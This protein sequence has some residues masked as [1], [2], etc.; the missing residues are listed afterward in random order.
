MALI[1]CVGS[2]RRGYFLGVDWWPAE[3]LPQG[4][5]A[6][7]PCVHVLRFGGGTNKAKPQ[8]DDTGAPVLFNNRALHAPLPWEGERF[9]VIFY[10]AGGLLHCTPTWRQQLVDLGFR[11]PNVFSPVKVVRTNLC[12]N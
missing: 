3:S 8:P 4:Q 1:V 12:S 7:H 5:K 2:F 11:P 6:A 9:S 10:S